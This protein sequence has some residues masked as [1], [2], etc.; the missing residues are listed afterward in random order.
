MRSCH[1][2]TALLV[3]LALPVPIGAVSRY[4][5]DQGRIVFVME[6]G[7]SAR[8]IQHCGRA[9][10]RELAGLESC[11]AREVA[12]VRSPGRTPPPAVA[13]AIEIQRAYWDLG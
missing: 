6:G 12:R 5:D 4:V 11:P 3:I 8:G 1:L 7:Y 13:K 9:V 2:L 10:L